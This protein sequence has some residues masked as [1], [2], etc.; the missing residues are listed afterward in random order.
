M[1]LRRDYREA[2]CGPALVV[3]LDVV[4]GLEPAVSGTASRGLSL[5]VALHVAVQLEQ[6]VAGSSSAAPLAAPFLICC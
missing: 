6:P 4:V 2:A 3:A 1:P 5:A